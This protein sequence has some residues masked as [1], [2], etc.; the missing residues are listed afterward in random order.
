MCLILFGYRTHRRYG[1]VLAA[2]R[3]ELYDR[4]AA[5]MAFWEDHRHILAGR[6][7][8][9]MGTWF[10][11]TRGGRMAAITNYRQPEIQ[12]A[13]APSRGHLVSDYLAD[14]VAPSDYLRLVAAR[15]QRYNGFNLLVGDRRSLHYY[16]NRGDGPRELEPGIYGLSNRLLNTPWPKVSRGRQGLGRILEEANGRM[17]DSLL[18]LLQDQ[19]VPDDNRLPATGI[20]MEWERILAPIFITSPTYGTRA[21]TLLTIDR[22]QQVRVVEVTWLPGQRMP[23]ADDENSFHYTMGT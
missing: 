21:S 20:G 23:K 8:K 9:M 22:D 5:P 12:V 14:S 16:S 15:A 17:H 2:N 11:I 3:D 19:T 13:D 6:D 10:G 1:M 7:L 4:P 18:K